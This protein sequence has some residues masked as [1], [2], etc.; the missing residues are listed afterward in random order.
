MIGI[1]VFITAVI[2]FLINVMFHDAEDDQGIKG[3]FTVFTL[4]LVPILVPSL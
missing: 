4:V 1:I 2:L 3:I